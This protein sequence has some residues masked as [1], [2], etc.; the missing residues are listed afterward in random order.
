[1]TQKRILVIDDEKDI[2]EA[3]A[4]HFV[5]EGHFI[6]DVATNGRE[7]LEK[8]H[9][10]KPDIIILDI[11]M[12]V[13]DGMTFLSALRDGEGERSERAVPVI[14]MTGCYM[15]NLMKELPISAIAV[16]PIYFEDLLK[17]VNRILEDV[18]SP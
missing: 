17:K 14:L 16:K 15:E 1:M 5:E 18:H 11:F 9:A 10:E 12:P 2:G 6:V 4:A 8:I 13:M 7:G 3:I